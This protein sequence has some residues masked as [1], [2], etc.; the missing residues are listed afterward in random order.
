MVAYRLSGNYDEEFRRRFMRI[1]FQTRT[2]SSIGR[3]T[4]GDVVMADQLAAALRDLGLTIDISAELKPALDRYDAVH[5]FNVV[6]PQELWLQTRNATEQGKPVFLSTVYC[7][8]A[9]FDRHGRRGF[10]GIIGRWASR[11]TVEAAKA[12]AR[13]A[14]SGEM[15][16]G[17][18][19]LVA[20]GYTNLQREVLRATSFYLPNSES[21]LARLECDLNVRI[22]RDR[23]AVVYNGVDGEFY[24][25][26]AL[27]DAPPPSPLAELRDS[28]LCV[29]RVTGGKNQ[30]GLLEAARDLP[31]TVV[32]AGGPSHNQAAYWRELVRDRPK[33]VRLLGH[34]SE[35]DKRW[36]YHLARVHVLPS[37]IET[38]GLASLEAAA[39]GCNV[40]TTNRGDAAEYFGDWAE[41][42]DPADPHSIRDAILRAYSRGDSSGLQAMVRTRYTWV[43]AA[44]DTAEAYDVGLTRHSRGGAV[45][46]SPRPEPEPLP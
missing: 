1:L 40:V 41:Y 27:S 3:Q 26:E 32:V 31:F 42:C 28:V 12:C 10:S 17:I 9:E 16:R 39:M 18:V 25:P 37:W 29:A 46:G 7:D 4:A 2:Q 44:K 43:R 35:S 33:N 8:V 19:A 21:E 36:L 15:H 13:A 24:T 23:V 20:R 38:T 6:R 22:P 34:V 11:N 5:V 30:R 14:T 45:D